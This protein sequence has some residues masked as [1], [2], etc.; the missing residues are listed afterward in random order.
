MSSEIWTIRKVLTWTSQHFEKRQVDSPRLTAEVLL[1]HVLKT[2]R[3][4]L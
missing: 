1:C 2:G 4:R 3:V